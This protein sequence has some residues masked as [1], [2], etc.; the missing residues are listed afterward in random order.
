L[1]SDSSNWLISGYCRAKSNLGQVKSRL[2]RHRRKSLPAVVSLQTMAGMTV[3]RAR[4]RFLYLVAAMA[5]AVPLANCTTSGG[6]PDD[7]MGRALVAPGKYRLYDCV[8]LAEVGRSTASREEELRGLIAKAG[9]GFGGSLVATAAY[10]PEYYQVHGEL[11]EIRRE[12]A[13]KNCKFAPGVPALTA[14]GKP[15]NRR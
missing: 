15:A 4:I 13:G 10:K 8:Q 11:N 6:T 3:Q 12:A 9:T 14:N 7:K 5:L 1:L 2:A